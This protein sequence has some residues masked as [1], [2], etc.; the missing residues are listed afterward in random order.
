MT[1]EE[2]LK[3]I[4]ELE[5]KY[6]E[7]MANAESGDELASMSIRFGGLRTSNRMAKAASDARIKAE[8]I[9]KE[10]NK[11]RSKLK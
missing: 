10:I 2:I 9:R 7:A 5:A 8:R 6:D 3:K 11:L 4:K 1:Q